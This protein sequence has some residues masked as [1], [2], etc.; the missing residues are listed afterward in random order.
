M[1]EAKEKIRKVAREFKAA[2]GRSGG[3]LVEGYKIEGAD[4]V[5]VAMGSLVSTM[6]VVV[7]ELRNKGK[8]V[9]LLKI[10][11]H[12]PFPEEEIKE[13]LLRAKNIAIVEKAVSMGQGGILDTEMKSILYD[14]GSKAR[15][16]NFVIGLG[17]RD[18]TE[19]DIV[20]IIEKTEAGPV[21]NE[22]ININFDLLDK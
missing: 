16:S 21:E 3:E 18:I 15:I 10:R 12:R 11:S 22:F 8:K 7:D 14:S 2:F 5:L 4:T 9:G 13:A 6:K 19:T 17:G 1:E 20:H